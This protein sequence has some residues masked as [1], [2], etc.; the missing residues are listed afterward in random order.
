LEG[1]L[2]QRLETMGKMQR[3]LAVQVYALGE[4]IHDQEVFRDNAE[5]VARELR[6]RYQ[7]A[8]SEERFPIEVRRVAY[9]RPQAEA[10]A[11]T[12]LGEIRN[13]EASLA[14]LKRGVEEA[15]AH[16]N[17]MKL[18]AQSGKNLLVAM[19]AERELVAV[20]PVSANTDALLAQAEGFLKGAERAAG[21]SPVRS[22]HDLLRA[23][24]A[25]GSRQITKEEATTFL[26]AKPRVHAASHST[27]RVAADGEP[28]SSSDRASRRT[29]D[30]NAEG[31]P[32]VPKAR[33]PIFRQEN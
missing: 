3:A 30:D 25:S 24:L 9:T 10:K 23:A 26:E 6:D 13:H 7:H 22:M 1:E 28:E 15:E 17:D 29:F 20:R 18:K 16:L 12:L 14:L 4:A 8:R 11:R 27:A 33:K 32:S 5:E 31:E 2:S 21:T 19:A